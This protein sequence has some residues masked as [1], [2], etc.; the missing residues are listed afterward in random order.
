[1]HHPLRQRNARIKEVPDYNAAEKDKIYTK[2]ENS[3]NEYINKISLK[4]G[5]SPL[6]I[7][8]N[9]NAQS[10]NPFYTP[11]GVVLTYTEDS[12]SP[13]DLVRNRPLSVCIQCKLYPVQGAPPLS[14]LDF[15]KE[16]AK[17]KINE[18]FKEYSVKSEVQ[19]NAEEEVNGIRYADVDNND[20]ALSSRDM[21][22][23]FKNTKDLGRGKMEERYVVMGYI[24]ARPDVY[25]DY[26]MKLGQM[27][28]EGKSLKE[29]VTS[30]LMKDHENYLKNRARSMAYAF[31]S[32]FSDK[33]TIE[34][35]YAGPPTDEYYQAPLAVEDFMQVNN[36]FEITT[37]GKDIDVEDGNEDPNL[38]GKNVIA[39]YSMCANPFTT[40]GKHGKQH[41]EK[42]KILILCTPA[43]GFVVS[44]V[45]K[46]FSG[47]AVGMSMSKFNQCPFKITKEEVNPSVLKTHVCS[48]D[49]VTGKDIINPKWKAGMY[50][51]T[52]ETF[53]DS[54]ANECWRDGII[55]SE[56]K[57]Y[58][59]LVVKQAMM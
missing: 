2:V 56:N 10:C 55:V 25:K 37:Y 30:P 39:Y 46:N 31:A 6:T 58:K 16:G 19:S 4:K 36:G 1:M 54:S 15:K 24:H 52:M 47:Y 21:I 3:L 26:K 5:V 29:I 34:H 45:N 57:Y 38:V 40:Y 9:H 53:F 44:R 43:D 23:I 8:I 59:P 14:D 48:V 33:V 49:P 51:N 28:K 17:E 20:L 42:G 41:Q 50:M 35:H 13:D 12:A 7:Q 27:V 22:G 32:I 18:W 11:S